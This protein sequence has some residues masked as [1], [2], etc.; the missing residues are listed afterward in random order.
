MSCQALNLNGLAELLIAGA[1]PRSDLLTPGNQSVSVRGNGDVHLPILQHRDLP[2]FLTGVAV[3]HI[4]PW[5]FPD[6][7][8]DGCHGFAVSRKTESGNSPL[9]HCQ[10]TSFFVLRNVPED[11]SAALVDPSQ[12]GAIGREG[13]RG[14]TE[15]F[16]VDSFD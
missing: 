8:R 10:S 1:F 15:R 3:P 12:L 16:D 6:R 9:G 2:F 14:G 4:D 11:E 13:E 5:F 7:F